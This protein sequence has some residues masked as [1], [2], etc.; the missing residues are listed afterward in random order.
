M[1]KCLPT[2]LAFL[3]FFVSTQRSRFPSTITF[4]QVERPPL[5]LLLV[6]ICWLILLVFIYLKMSLFCLHSWRIFSLNIDRVLSRKLFFVVV[7]HFK[8]L[9]HCLLVSIVSDENSVNFLV[10]VLP[11]TVL[12]LIQT[13][14]KTFSL[15]FVFSSLTMM[16]LHVVFLCTYPTWGSRNFL[17][18]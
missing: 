18:L 5:A 4:L 13:A 7:Q 17:N 15:T 12:R 1:F 6:Q 9:F 3:V 2:Y 8:M 11:Y 14:F 10:N 16:R